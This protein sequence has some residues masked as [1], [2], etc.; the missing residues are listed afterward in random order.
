MKAMYSEADFFFQQDGAS[1]HTGQE[2]AKSL[3]KIH[4]KKKVLRNPPNSPELYLSGYRT[5]NILGMAQMFRRFA[6]AFI[7]P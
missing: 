7:P 3:E 2:S 5:W 6:G 4:G 1:S